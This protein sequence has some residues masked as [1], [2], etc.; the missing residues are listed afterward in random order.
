MT[1][2]YDV[3][4]AGYGPVGAVA[5]GLLGQAGLR[6]A[7]FE[8]TTSVYHLPRAAH[9]DAEIM[10]VL[11]QLGV[12]DEVQA[13]CAPV[14]AM[15]FVNACGDALLRFDLD[16]GAGWMFYQPDL[17]RALRAGVDALDSVSVRLAHE[18]TGFDQDD[19]GVSVRVRA[20]GDA[21]E[22]TVRARV[23]IGADGAR[24]VVRKQLDVSSVD[25][26]FDQP[27]LVV[28][29]L[30]RRPLELPELVQQICDPA[31]P[32]T[33]IPM[34]GLRRRWEFMLLDGETVEEM[35][36][37]E[38]IAELLSPWVQPDDVEIVRAVVYSFHAVLAEQWRDRRVFLI[39]DAAHQM[40]PFLGQGMCSGVRDAHNLA[41]KL[42]L[43]LRG[44]AR[45]DL[46][47]TYESERSPHVRSII[48][49]AV[50]LGGL[51]QTTDPEVA[52]SRDAMM[53]NPDAKEP[54]RSEMPG[55]TTG[56]LVDGGGG[57]VHDALGSFELRAPVAP[58]LP[59]DLDAWWRAIG[60]RHVATDP[61]EAG[62]TI[63][64]PDGYVFGSSDDPA[65]LL[66][67]LRS[68]LS[69]EATVAAHSVAST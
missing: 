45:D 49:T 44:L 9:M 26:E 15:H 20:V 68:M 51:L 56:V 58:V 61:A 35:E 4:I 65:A 29:T 39:G 17:E 23:L 3:V 2:S 28:D 47:D 62:A 8:P 34:C 19:D 37:P 13:A 36:T 41:W 33:F 7:V 16:E 11:E 57:R 21:T 40:P 10:R 69:S 53:L 60:G 50:S 48:E 43:V 22:T 18:V 55:L 54:A 59:V 6:V 66:S 24:S 25:L 1:D 63:V 67:A 30:L 14:K 64:R 38:R 46:L 31:R 27:W 42:A 12:R 32:T 52:A 5:A